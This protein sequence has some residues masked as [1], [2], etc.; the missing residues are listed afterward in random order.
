MKGDSIV[1]NFHKS[2]FERGIGAPIY[3]NDIISAEGPYEEFD[4]NVLDIHHIN[5]TNAESWQKIKSGLDEGINKLLDWNLKYLPE[6]YDIKLNGKYPI[7]SYR[8]LETEDL[9][10]Y[11]KKELRLMRN[12]IFARYGFRFK[13]HDLEIYFD[14]E[15][16]YKP[17][18]DNV[19]IYL[20]D[21]EKENIDLIQTLERAN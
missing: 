13:S 16:W 18:R 11:N 12:E 3:T 1:M 6:K 5:E 4:D 15:D 19:D 2:V 21:I 7:A 9:A 10:G 8:K 14:N 17:K 20:S